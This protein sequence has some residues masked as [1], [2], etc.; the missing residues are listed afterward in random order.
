MDEL[1]D[2]AGAAVFFSVFGADGVDLS[3]PEDDEP[4]D[5][6]PLDDESLAEPPAEPPDDLP[7]P[8]A[9]AAARESVR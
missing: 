2:E 5:E 3:E 8:S 9:F 7:D 1:P 6:D 4:E